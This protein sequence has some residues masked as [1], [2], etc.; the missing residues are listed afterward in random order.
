MSTEQMVKKGYSDYVLNC[1]KKGDKAMTF[2]E[3]LL[4]IISGLKT[5]SMSAV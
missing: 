2:D 3:Y 1:E 4:V 5:S